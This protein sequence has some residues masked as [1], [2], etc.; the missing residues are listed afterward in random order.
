[1]TSADF[2]Q[3]AAQSRRRQ[4]P[5]LRL[6]RQEREYGLA[7]KMTHCGSWLLYRHYL[8]GGGDTRIRSANFCKRFTLCPWCARRRSWKAVGAYGPKVAQV[9]GARPGL[10]P[11]MI[12][13]TIRSGPDVG[14]RLRC[15]RGGFKAMLTERRRVEAG[16]RGHRPIEWC[17]VDGAIK[18]IE[19]KR[20]KKGW[21]VHMHVF[22]LLTAFVDQK[23]L[24]KDWERFTGDGSR[25]VD[26]RAAYAKPG[27]LD[28]VITPGLVE[29]LK[30]ALK[31]GDLAPRD[32]LQAHRGIARAKVR[33]LDSQGSLRGVKI[34]EIDSDPEAEGAYIDFLAFWDFIRSDYS[35]LPAGEVDPAKRKVRRWLDQT[36]EEYRQIARNPPDAT[37][38]DSSTCTL[39]PIPSS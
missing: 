13:L 27:A 24:S 26:V 10:L 16:C 18:S 31:F 38:A 39:T 4:V 20:G 19:V 11:A 36:A 25:I 8:E 5:L 29:V 37:P 30:Y 32:L 35:V 34:P 23:R 28:D 2:L 6:L 15:L 33:L 1:M 3:E 9:I 7:Y 17:K 21:H 22:C 14:E 12:T